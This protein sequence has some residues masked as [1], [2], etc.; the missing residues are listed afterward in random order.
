M[1]STIFCSWV[2]RGPW[3]CKAISAR[4]GSYIGRSRARLRSR[5]KCRAVANI[6]T[7]IFV[8]CSMQ[9]AK[10]DQET[11]IH[12]A[13]LQREGVI[14][15]IH[16]VFNELD[17]DHS[18][19]MSLMEFEEAISDEGMVTYLSVLGL[20]VTDAKLLFCLLDRDRS[21]AIDIEDFI[22]GCL[23]LRGEAKN[24]DMAMISLQSDWL[25]ETMEDVYSKL[26]E[27]HGTILPTNPLNELPASMFAADVAATSL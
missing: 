27:L 22:V 26:Q 2:C 19:E 9:A 5:N 25:V 3:S 12:E 6:I 24:L 15:R 23:K 20:E 17:K 16:E 21:G 18:G 7:G 1:Y 8:D 4:L 10:Q 14:S 11:Q 13:A